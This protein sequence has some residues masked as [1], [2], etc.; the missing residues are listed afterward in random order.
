MPFKDRLKLLR[1]EKGI[2]QERLAEDLEVPSS[3]IRRYE[4]SDD[5]TPKRDRLQ[6]IANYFNC[7]IDYL[8][9]RTNERNPEDT[10]E[11]DYV[12]PE[13]EYERVIREA[14]LHYGVNLREDPVVNATM[15]ELILGVA[16]S[17]QQ[18]K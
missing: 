16:K 17:Q 14:E 10:K 3:T 7:S 1:K 8:L 18:K 4:S 13:S 12:L 2:T 15:R 6:L 11:Y 9:E 5:G